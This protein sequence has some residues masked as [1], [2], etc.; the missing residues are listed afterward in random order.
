MTQTNSSSDNHDRAV[1]HFT[2]ARAEF[3][4]EVAHDGSAPI[5]ASRVFKGVGPTPWTFVDLVRVPVGADIGLHTHAT[6]NEEMYIIV[7]GYGR[8]QIDGEEIHIGAGD[9]IINRPGGSHGLVNLGDTALD[10]VVVE[11]ATR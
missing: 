10:L 11:V 1:R 4:Y 6:G 5:L 7:C 2:F 9:V 8:M 3:R